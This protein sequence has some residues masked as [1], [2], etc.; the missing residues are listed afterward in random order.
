MSISTTRAEIHSALLQTQHSSESLPFRSHLV[1]AAPRH[2]HLR[3]VDPLDLRG[4][5]RLPFGEPVARQ[6]QV[7]LELAHAPSESVDDV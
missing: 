6:S 1:E 5:Q 2:A 4:H 7:D 3:G